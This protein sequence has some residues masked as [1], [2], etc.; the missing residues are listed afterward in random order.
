MRKIM[1]FVVASALT[2]AGLAVA[3]PQVQAAAPAKVVQ[4]AMPEKPIVG[5]AGY[6]GGPLKSKAEYNSLM[7]KQQALVTCGGSFTYHWQGASEQV[8]IVGSVGTGASSVAVLASQHKPFVDTSCSTGTHSLFEVAAEDDTTQ[9]VIEAGWSR[10]NN[11]CGATITTICFFIFS[12]VNGVPQGYNSSNPGWVD[13]P[14]ETAVNAGTALASTAAGAAPTAFYQYRIER[15]TNPTWCTGTCGTPSGFGTGWQIIQ[16]NQGATDRIIG[17]FKDTVWTAAPTPT[18]FT[19]VDF[20]QIFGEQAD[21]N[22]TACTDSGSGVFGTSA[23]P[24]AAARVVAYSLAGAPAGVTNVPG[25]IYVRDSTGVSPSP[26]DP[27]AYRIY[28]LPTDLDQW[29]WGGPGYN[30]AGTGTGSVGSC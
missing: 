19:A 20:L 6:K 10:D 14:N 11:M 30:S 8:G 3:S 22:T 13:N 7:Q 15:V 18:S 9:Q 29:T 4:H 24:S 23:S 12:W 17:G 25:F 2:L 16:K 27:T 26:D 5:V 28:Q 21:K 1:T